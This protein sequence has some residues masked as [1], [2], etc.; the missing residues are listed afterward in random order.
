MTPIAYTQPGMYCRC[1]EDR[2]GESP[3][4]SWQLAVVLAVQDYCLQRAQGGNTADDK[5]FWLCSAFC[6]VVNGHHG[7]PSAYGAAQVHLAGIL[8]L[9]SG[10]TAIC[11]TGRSRGPAVPTLPASTSGSISA[12]WRLACDCER[13]AC[14]RS[15]HQGVTCHVSRKQG[16]K[17]RCRL[18]GLGRSHRGASCECNGLYPGYIQARYTGVALTAIKVGTAAAGD[19]QEEAALCSRSRAA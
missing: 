11:H 16:P 19:E 8:Y 17:V 15:A 5:L 18:A 10:P 4:G 3:N 7:L 2:H 14:D 6:V 13:Q 12:R 9:I 1:A